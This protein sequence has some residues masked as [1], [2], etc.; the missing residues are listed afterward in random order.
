MGC[1][2][3]EWVRVW[4]LALLCL[5]AWPG[6]AVAQTH[7]GESADLRL[8]RSDDGLYLSAA[9]QFDLPEL[10]EDA[11]YK[12]IPVFFVAEAQVSRER[13]YWSDRQVATATRHLRL[14]YQPLTRR[15]RLSTSSTA[16]SNTGLGVVLGQNFDELH[17]AL[18]AM[19]RIS[20]WKIADA[21]EIDADAAHTVHF[22]FRLDMSQL[23]RPLQIGAVGSSGWSLLLSRQQRLL[24]ETGR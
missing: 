4:I 9:L 19:Q 5:V 21:S 2:L 13:W 6:I 22:R 8:E 18:M 16:F 14:S 20:R 1:L 10:A 23:P 11:L 3:R 15:W 7:A 17:D 24:P 12:G